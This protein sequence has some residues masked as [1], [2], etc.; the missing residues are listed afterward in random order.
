[1]VVSDHRGILLFVLYPTTE[2][3]GLVGI[4]IAGAVASASKYVIAWRG[5]HIVNPAAFGATVLSI[6][7]AATGVYALRFRRLVGG[8]SQ[9]LAAP[10][11]CWASSSSH[12]QTSCAPCCCSR[13]RARRRLGAG[14]SRV[15]LDRSGGRRR[16]G[17][18]DGA[19]VV[20]VL[21]FLAAFMFSSR[22]PPPRRW[23]Q[24]I[25]AVVVGVL[26]GLPL[27]VGVL[28]SAPRRPS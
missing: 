26:A 22:S 13:D 21:L 17:A 25:V 11:C 24:Y 7:T 19:V 20:A 10:Y 15:R 23:R 27:S 2:A 18:V 14:E 4:A 1:M 8:N 12:G 9:T 3:M 6:V 28:T 16:P 5:R